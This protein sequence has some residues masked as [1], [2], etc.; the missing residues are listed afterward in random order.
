MQ[1]PG[2]HWS[3]RA[4][5]VLAGV[6]AV[7]FCALVHLI[8]IA[9]ARAAESSGMAQFRKDIQPVLKEFCFDCHGDGAS[10]G[11]VSFDDFK[12]DAAML[13]NH[14]LWLKALQNVR[15]GIMPPPKKSQPTAE[16][17]LQLERWIKSAAFAID[18]ANPD[19]GRVT[20]RRLNRVEY[21]NTIRDLMNV[22]FDTEKEFP[23]DDAGHGFDNIGDVLTLPPMLLEKYLAAAK[24]IV[25][26]AV[27]DV[28]GVPAEK[29]I[30]GRSFGGPDASSAA[31]TNRGSMSG[32]GLTLSYYEPASVSNTFK[33][34]RAGRYQ[35]V[36]DFAANERFVDNQFDY[37]KC[38]LVFKAD[39]R[40]LHSKEYTREG[41]K[42]FSYEFGLEWKAGDHE[43]VIELQP[44]TLD[45]KQ[46][47]SLVIRIDS[48]TVRGPMEREHWVRPK[49]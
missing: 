43:L 45:Q 10:K 9:G 25:T 36:L 34:D 14:D 15:A 32:N 22:D 5:Q 13:E 47:R 35:L 3:W 8:A 29:V 23:P 28:P 42:A 21:R 37:N 6:R 27:P 26:R 46:V 48:V 30:T 4:S 49:N 20:V 44:L 19:P 33:I 38:W 17:K 2:G 18:P 31:R 7:W 1:K 16:Q 39:G 41:G 12:S 40:E 24:T 11:G